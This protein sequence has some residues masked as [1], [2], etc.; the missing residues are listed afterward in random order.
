M[1]SRIAVYGAIVAN[2]AIA[3]TKFIVAG[4][5]GSSAMLSEGVHSLVDTGNDALLLVGLKRAERPASAQHPYGHGKELYFWSLIVAVLIFGVGGG[6]SLYEGILHIRHPEPLRDAMWN[7]VVLAAAFV[8]EGISF[9]IA[10]RE[11]SKARGDTPFWEAL[12]HSKDPSSYT[13]L[14]EDGA[15]LAGLLIAGAGIFCSHALDMPEL[16]GVA[17]VLIGL[18]LAGV[19]VLLIRESRGLLVG[20]GLRPETA[21][22][23]RGM[24][25]EETSVR[26]VGALLSMYIGAEEVLV[27]LD[28]TFDSATPVGEVATAIHRIEARVRERFPKISRIYVEAVNRPAQ[29]PRP[30]GG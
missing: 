1:A 28:A 10:W 29:R 7:Y 24:V 27:T 20:E 14:A 6:V 8:F 11:F 30:G 13:V 16:D 25:Q 9:G 19:A 3:V 21:Q 15:A 23:I 26:E 18:L 22:A 4:L 17:S 12:H 2:V 5:T